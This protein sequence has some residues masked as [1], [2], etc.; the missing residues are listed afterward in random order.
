MKT[1]GIS[2]DGTIRDFLD[3]FDQQY[4]K[5]FIHNPNIVAMNEKDMTFKEQTAEEAQAIEDTIKEKERE[6]ITLPVDSYDIL[7]HYKFSSK[8]IE[9]TKFSETQEGINLDPIEFTPRQNLEKFLY[10]DY[11]FQVFGQA[12]EYKGAMDAVNKLQSIGLTKEKFEIVLLCPHRS[13]AISAT[14]FFLSKI[15]CRIRKL[16]FVNDDIDKWNY[17]DILIDASPVALQNKPDGKTSIKIDHLFN[18]WDAADYSFST[19]K[20][21]CNE[22]LF[23]RILNPDPSR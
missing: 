4:R 8:S 22:A 10:D 15:N 14:M 11:P 2:I 1:I 12:D 3:K 9:M 20:E 6:L 19:I 17:C 21:A 7:N 16:I 18:Q 5:V 13:K 23:D